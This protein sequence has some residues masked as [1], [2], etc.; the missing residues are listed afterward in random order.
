MRSAVDLLRLRGFDADSARR[1]AEKVDRGLDCALAAIDAFVT[2]EQC[3][4]GSMPLTLAPCSLGQLIDAA[5]EVAAPVLA[6]RSQRLA[7]TPA[8][9]PMAVRADSARSRQVITAMLEQAS[10]TAPQLSQIEMEARAG[11][12]G[13]EV[14]VRFALEAAAAPS[15]AWFETYRSRPRGSRLALRSAR[16]IMTLQQGR[17]TLELEPA[18]AQLVAQFAAA[19]VQ[20]AT[21][22]P[23]PAPRQAPAARADGT[24]ILIVDDSHEVRSVYREA[25]QA[26]GYTVT[27]AANAEEALS[28]AH[29][30]A[31]D[32]ALI[33]IQL[34]WF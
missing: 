27:E 23:A 6:A 5:R 10:A 2:A 32:V 29:E 3:E 9:G 17:L 33:D 21:A 7:F 26:L 12:A 4:S 15:E 16:Q 30:R 19:A 24:H 13:A 31:P 1:T 28:T 34:S 18:G 11:T 25:L 22:A 20:A 14:R 8:A